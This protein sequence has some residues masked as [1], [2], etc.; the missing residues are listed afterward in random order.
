MN[1]VTSIQHRPARAL[2]S[3]KNDIPLGSLIEI[4]TEDGQ[5]VKLHIADGA[6][7]ILSFMALKISPVSRYDITVEF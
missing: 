6:I 1:K 3:E 5:L 2:R 7:S 4:E